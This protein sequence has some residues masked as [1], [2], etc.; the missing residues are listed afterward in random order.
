MNALPSKGSR[1]VVAMSGGV[2]SSVAA[3]WLK[4]Q[5]YETI[6][7]SLQLHDAS[8]ETEKK[9]GTCC[10]ISDIQDARRVAAHIGIP[11]YVSDMEM[12]FKT[13]VIDDFIREYLEGRTPNPCVRCNEKVKFSRLL[14][15]CLDLGADYLATGHYATIRNEG[16][17]ELHRGTFSEKDQSYFLFS[18]READLSRC[19]FPVGGFSKEQV[20]QLARDFGLSVA[21][22]PDSQEICFVQGK[23]YQEFIEKHVPASLRRPGHIVDESGNVLGEHSGLYQFTVGQRKGIGVAS[24]APQFIVG[25]RSSEN[26]VIVGPEASLFRRDCLAYAVRWINSAPRNNDAIHAKIRYRAMESPCVLEAVQEDQYCV[27][28]LKPQRAITPG[29]AIVFYE[30]TRVAGGGWIH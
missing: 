7:V 13:S 2:D 25:I 14:E 10:T 8:Q 9:Y 18:T 5:G 6:G 19:V 28:F 16:R 30:G 20:R 15:W 24:P 23:S 21:G 27:T 17:F 12:V 22:K 26:E 29:Q 1:V 4:H 11:F 3:A